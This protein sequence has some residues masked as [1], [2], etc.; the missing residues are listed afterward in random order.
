MSNDEIPMSKGNPNDEI[1]M[2]KE[3]RNP[4]DEMTTVAELARVP[5][6]ANNVL[7]SGGFSYA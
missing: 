6:N 3:I 5:T 1:P 2:T 4:N 7:N